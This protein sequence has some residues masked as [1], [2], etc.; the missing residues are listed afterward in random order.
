MC[1]PC[2]HP[3]RALHERGRLPVPRDLTVSGPEHHPARYRDPVR[4]L[5]ACVYDSKHVF[6]C[7]GRR[8]PSM[9]RRERR[10]AGRSAPPA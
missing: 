5:A 10:S 9:S 4:Q 6:G 2:G 7:D 8:S 3:Y 1:A